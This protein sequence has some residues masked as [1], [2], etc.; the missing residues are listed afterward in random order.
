MGKSRRILA[1]SKHVLAYDL[2]FSHSHRLNQTIFLRE[3]RF[4]FQKIQPKWRFLSRFVSDFDGF[5]IRNSDREVALAVIKLNHKKYLSMN[6][7][8]GD[9]PSFMLDACK[10][11]GLVLSML[12]DSQK[13]QE[14]GLAALRENLASLH[15]VKFYHRDDPLFIYQLREW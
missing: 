11:N 5:L 15:D 12:N 7:A 13:G 6:S 1:L 4:L 14:I 3:V 2:L 8:L 9:D 10:A